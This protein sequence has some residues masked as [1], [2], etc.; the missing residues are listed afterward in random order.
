[1]DTKI[2]RV[3][4]EI[5][6]HGQVAAMAMALYAVP[7]GAEVVGKVDAILTMPGLGDDWRIR[8]AVKL[9]ND[10]P[11][12]PYLLLAGHN[13]KEKTARV[14]S[15]DVLKE[16]FGLIDMDRVLIE[17]S[18]EHT[19]EQAEWVVDKVQEL[20][21]ANLAITVSQYHLLRAYLTILKAF[22]K[23]NLVPPIMIPF[24]A[25]SSP[26]TLIPE[27]GESAWT[28]A[29]GEIERIISYQQK[30]DVATYAELQNYLATIWESPLL[31]EY[32]LD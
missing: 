5:S 8:Q 7:R 4:N 13:Q 26:E 1:M 10:H 17:I 29:N 2:P 12:T 16:E 25:A 15:T 22:Y 21:I 6:D 19:L 9:R 27:I 30:G 32:R 23:K 31:K 24:P 14:F 28:M 18:A 11:G 3:V 20:G